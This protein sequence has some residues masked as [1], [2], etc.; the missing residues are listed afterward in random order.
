MVPQYNGGN[1]CNRGLGELY[2]PSTDREALNDMADC[3]CLSAPLY[4]SK[5]SSFTIGGWII[6]HPGFLAAAANS[7]PLGQCLGGFQGRSRVKVHGV[8]LKAYGLWL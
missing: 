3:N 1:I 7:N 5:P 8:G 2:V 6:S 4:T